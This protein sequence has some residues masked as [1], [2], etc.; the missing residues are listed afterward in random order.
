VTFTGNSTFV[1]DIALGTAYTIVGVTPRGFHFPDDRIEFWAPS[2]LTRPRDTRQ[3]TSMFAQLREGISIQTATAELAAIIAG[4]R[5]RTTSHEPFAATRFELVR[6]EDEVTESVRAALLVLTGAVGFVLLIACA[7]VANLLLARTAA[8]EREIAV[9][10]SLGAG[11]GRLLRQLLT[12]SLLLA[13]LGGAA[14]TALAHGGV[15]M[16]QS[17][18]TTLSRFD[19][20][21]AVTF[22]RL[23]DI[24]I[25]PAVLIFALVTSILTGLLFGVA[26][27]LRA[28]RFHQMAPYRRSRLHHA[29]VIAE[30]ALALPLIVGCGLLLRSFVNLV[31]VDPGYD[32]S[33]ALTFQVGA[34]GDRYS[35]G[36]VETVFERS[37]HPPPRHPRWFNCR[38]HTRSVRSRTSRRLDRRPTAP[39]DGTSVSDI[40][41]RS[42]PGSSPGTGLKSRGRC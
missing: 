37:R 41:K 32:A 33:H 29:L 23:A 17:L 8:R 31:T 20:G 40:F 9:R 1:G 28:V 15:A 34:R 26:P 14:G 18:G 38:T 22:P 24:A 10:V 12:E 3:R 21:D 39:T 7:N 11:R 16:F 5:G 25:D 2:P 4:V 13:L 6:I 42:A 36:S 35:P 19:L 27:A 30:I